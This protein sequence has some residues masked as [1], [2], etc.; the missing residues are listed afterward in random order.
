M[1]PPLASLDDVGRGRFAWG[2]GGAAA[3]QPLCP[4]GGLGRIRRRA[5]RAW[6]VRSARRCS[7]VSEPSGGAR[8]RSTSRALQDT[9]GEPAQRDRGDQDQRR[10]PA[11]ATPSSV[12]QVERSASI[13]SPR[14]RRRRSVLKRSSPTTGQAATAAAADATG[15]VRA[16][17]ASPRRGVRASSTAGWCAMSAAAW[18]SSRAPH[19]RDRSRSRRC[20]SRCRTDRVDPPSGRSLGR[21]HLEGHDQVDDRALMPLARSR[22]TKARA[23]ARAFCFAPP[24]S[25]R[26]L[27]LRVGCTRV[28]RGEQAMARAFRIVVV[29]A[30]GACGRRA[31]RVRSRRRADRRSRRQPSRRC[32]K[33]VPG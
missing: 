12:R 30:D 6:P 26:T 2:D 21:G 16:Q 13:A 19:R 18:R 17:P 29:A 9:I 15:S 3:L 28:L 25:M 11:T 31:G 1:K 32:A 23:D 7:R 33:A 24:F 14:S 27:R 20:R 4:A 8:R 5:R 10:R 22:V